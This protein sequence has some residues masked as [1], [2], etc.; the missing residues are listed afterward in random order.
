MTSDNATFNLAIWVIY[1]R[2]RDYPNSFVVR[3]WS[4][5]KPARFCQVFNTLQE[6]RDAIPNGLCC[7]E[8]QPDDDP[9]IKETWL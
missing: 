8:R 5:G 3:R 2:P 9:S 7:L 1:E 4:G 6:A